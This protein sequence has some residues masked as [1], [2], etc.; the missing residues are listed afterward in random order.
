MN[1]F[2]ASSRPM[3]ERIRAK[4]RFV[5]LL[6]WLIWTLAILL[7]LLAPIISRTHFGNHRVFSNRH[8]PLKK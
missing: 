7:I 8:F 4:H 1:R 6:I 3:A 5:L 2:R